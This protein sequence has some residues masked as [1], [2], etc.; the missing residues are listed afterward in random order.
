MRCLTLATA[1]T[2][3][4]IKS[5]FVSR[6]HE[7]NLISLVR[8]KGFEVA[9]LPPP[10]DVVPSSSEYEQWLGSRVSVDA[11]ETLKMIGEGSSSAWMIT[12]HYGIDDGWERSVRAKLSRIIALDDLANR[13]HD[14]DVLV[15]SSFQRDRGDYT[16]LVP[17]QARI[18]AGTTYCLLRSEFKEA[19]PQAL[20]KSIRVPPARILVSLGGIDIQNMT[21]EVIKE[22]EQSSL[23]D[24][25][26]L[27]VVIG[28]ASPHAEVLRSQASKCRLNVSVHQ[29]VS[30]MAERLLVADLCIGAVGSSV[31]ERCCLGCP[32]LVATL[33]ANQKEGANR[34]E[35]AG[36]VV[37][38]EPTVK[39]QLRAI[40][41]GLNTQK[42]KQL[43]DK[44]LSLVDGLGADRVVKI[45]LEQE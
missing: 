18:L 8:E 38:F 7:G 23:P 37:S 21:L 33:A 26:C 28:P 32:S 1:L 44:G 6:P 24:E 5:V 41:N 12:D 36:A 29:G 14:C 3:N 34:L 45:L 22:L 30:N 20:H 39:G 13:K 40:I 35:A 15:D 43:S 31:W 25:T 27:D 4:G 11:E 17:E 9:E 19:R 42:L 10:L 2:K 16:K